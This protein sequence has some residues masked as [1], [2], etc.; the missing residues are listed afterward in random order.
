ME[1]VLVENSQSLLNVVFLALEQQRD[2][3]CNV[4]ILPIILRCETVS[5][6]FRG[7]VLYEDFVA[8]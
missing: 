4:F 2:L 1:V 6:P 5:G 3:S 7:F 8:S